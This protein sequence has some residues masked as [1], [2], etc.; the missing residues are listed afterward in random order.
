MVFELAGST[1]SQ[2]FNFGVGTTAQVIEDAINAVSDATGVTATFDGTETIT[3]NSTGYG[4][5][6]KVVV[7]TISGT[8]TDLE[9]YKDATDGWLSGGQAEGA[10][11][12]AL[13]NGIRAAGDGNHFSINT[14]TLSM[15]A[16]VTDGSSANFEFSIA[17]GGALFQVGPDVV[18]NQQAR[19]GIGSVNSANLGGASGRLYE[20]GSGQGAELAADPTKAAQIIN[21][22]INK[23]TS[24]RG[25]LGAFQK[26]TLDSNIASLNDTLENLIS[27]ESEIRD[28]DFA[29]EAAA[30][31]RS[32]ILVQSGTSVLAIAN[33]NPQ[34]VLALLR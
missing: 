1:G 28:A 27:A 31:T 19:I 18:S 22:V 23:V 7:D 24:L 21:E 2:V 3:L 30:L 16:T 20:L 32:Q 33:Q 26:T 29:V 8:L 25:R 10:D 17:G 11:I 6:A 4:A 13:V 15:N 12:V 5:K 14:A 9:Y 34:N